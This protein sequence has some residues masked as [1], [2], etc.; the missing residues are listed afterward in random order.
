MYIF[1]AL[2]SY[3]LLSGS[4]SKA[5]LDMLCDIVLFFFGGTGDDFSPNHPNQHL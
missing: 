5:K 4:K 1:V 3:L 2:A